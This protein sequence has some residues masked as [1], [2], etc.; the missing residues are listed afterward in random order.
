MTQINDTAQALGLGEIR[1]NVTLDGELPYPSGGS[2]QPNLV[3]TDQGVWLLAQAQGRDPLQRNV[4]TNPTLR[5]ETRLLGDRLH[6]DGLSFGI[7]LGRSTEVKAALG[8][9]RIYNQHPVVGLPQPAAGLFVEAATPVQDA[10]LHANL[11]DQEQVLAWLETS[12]QRNVPSELIEEQNAPIR[13]LLT[14]GRAV[15]VAI[16][17]VGDVQELELP[18]RALDVE[19]GGGRRSVRCTHHMWASTRT[20]GERFRALAKVQAFSRAERLRSVAQANHGNHPSQALALLKAIGEELNASDRLVIALRAVQL[21][22][23]HVLDEAGILQDLQTLEAQDETGS[24]LVDRLAPWSVSG[25]ALLPLVRLGV[26]RNP[27]QAEWYLPLHR[28]AHRAALESPAEAA[29]ADLALAEHLLLAKRQEE[30]QVLLED[31]YASLPDEQLSDLLPPEDADLTAGQAGQALRIRTLELLAAAR[32]SAEED[33]ATLAELARLQPLMWT[34]VQALI[35]AARH[36]T[37]HAKLL[38][39][40][41]QVLAL[42]KD[43]KPAAQDLGLISKPAPLSATQLAALQHP[44]ARSEGTLGWLQS[45]L[46]KQR[47]PDQTTIKNYCE[48]LSP[49]RHKAA[50]SAVNVAS[51]GLGMPGVEAYISHGTLAHGLR[52]YDNEPSYLLIGG[53]HLYEED[54]DYLGPAEL[55]FAVGA[56]IAHICYKHARVTSGEVWDGTVHKLGSALDIA[57]TAL[58]FGSYAPVGKVLDST[59]TH[60]LLSSVFNA[61]TLSR[62]YKTGDGAKAISTVGGDVTKAL[63]KS[64]DSIGAAKTLSNAAG[65]A[66]DKVRAIGSGPGNERGT[67]GVDEQKLIAAHRVMQLTADR[68]GLV[69]S[70]DIRASVRAVFLTSAR[71]LPEL[72][73]AEEHGLGTAL[74][75]RDPKGQMLHQDLAIR[76]GAL[77]HFYLEE[78]YAQM[79]AQ[80]GSGVEVP[81]A[82]AS[83][84]EE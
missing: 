31:R 70:G 65:T 73:I 57:A 29:A 15:L 32:G 61:T 58:T 19:D 66:M 75:R 71:Y 81:A 10:W 51:L 28:S 52:A 25:A 69:L 83:A 47:R 63:A 68:A 48:R 79:R 50:V 23:A 62:I 17:E 27:E 26:D 74:A 49:K 1:R 77:I 44:L 6:V 36:T 46:A 2:A 53:A 33:V 84:S 37:E 13:Y 56:E 60:R 42:H 43:C 22:P 7:P 14:D 64:S 24:D 82:E 16:N 76:I 18:Q 40:S 34:R 30:A 59:A 72:A 67:L 4:S 12:E 3:Q 5:L 11:R 9:G 41:E 45:W 55:R 39:R 20:N 21:D 54:S 35:D 38:A 78:D 80:L 8:A